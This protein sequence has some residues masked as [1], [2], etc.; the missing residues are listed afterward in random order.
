LF[1]YRGK[2]TL[3]QKSEGILYNI[4]LKYLI[5]PIMAHIEPVSWISLLSLQ[6]CAVLVVFKD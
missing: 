6:Q 5:S 2:L 4:V 3:V 1:T